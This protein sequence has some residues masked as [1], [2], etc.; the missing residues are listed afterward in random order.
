MFLGGTL[1]A[2]AAA[3]FAAHFVAELPCMLVTKTGM[4]VAHRHFDYRTP[5]AP[6]NLAAAILQARLAHTKTVGT[7]PG[8]IRHKNLLRGSGRQNHLRIKQRQSEEKS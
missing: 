4:R 3:E 2:V 7:V 6:L 1:A 5:V 8:N